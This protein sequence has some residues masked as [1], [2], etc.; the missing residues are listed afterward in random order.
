[1]KG[2]TTP[3]ILNLDTR[4]ILMVSFWPPFSWSRR[5][6]KAR[7]TW[8]FSKASGLPWFDMEHKKVG[9]SGPWGPEPKYNQSVNQS[10]T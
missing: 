7:T 4:W 5:I 2:G 6:L 10:V 3:L 9:A 8:N 1:M